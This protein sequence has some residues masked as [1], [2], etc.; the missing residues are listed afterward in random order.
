MYS[1]SQKINPFHWLNSATA[2]LCTHLKHLFNARVQL[3]IGP[4]LLCY[5]DDRRSLA[6][7]LPHVRIAL[8]TAVQDAVER[9]LLRRVKCLATAFNTIMLVRAVEMVL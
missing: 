6:Q 3:K 9:S 1:R 7:Q 5:K 2:E 4:R 8:Y